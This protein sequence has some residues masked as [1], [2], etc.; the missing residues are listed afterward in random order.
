VPKIKIFGTNDSAAP[1]TACVPR[2]T[3]DAFM[4]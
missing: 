2:L 4:V 1:T 3:C